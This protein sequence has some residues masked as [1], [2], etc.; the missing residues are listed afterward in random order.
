M[1]CPLTPI[2]FGYKLTCNSTVDGLNQG[3]GSAVSIFS[4][5]DVFTL[6]ADVLW[7]QA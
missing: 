2:T 6:Q 3:L 7:H 5:K 4:V 1:V